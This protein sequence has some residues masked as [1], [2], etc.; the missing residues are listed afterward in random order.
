MKTRGKDILKKPVPMKES[1]SELNQKRYC[2]YHRSVGHD[3]D[4]CRDLKGEI[5]SLIRRGHLK[6]FVARPPRGGEPP[7]HQDRA[8]L[9][10]PPQHGRGEIH[11]IVGGSQ[12]L[13][14][15]RRHRRK[16][17]RE[18]H[19]SYQVLSGTIANPDAEKFSFSEEDASHVL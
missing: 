14:G 4:D 9:P 10:P 16:L 1:S 2:R 11:M 12:Y 6:E 5:E 19:N 8:E 7:Q 13:E 15:S 3:T 17:S 18:A